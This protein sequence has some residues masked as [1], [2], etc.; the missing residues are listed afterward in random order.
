MEDHRRLLRR[1]QVEQRVGL[2]RSSIYARLQRG[3][4]PKPV[5]LGPKSVRLF[6]HEIDV[7]IAAKAEARETEGK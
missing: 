7:W 3:E 4:F 5:Q 1:K 2:E 6:E